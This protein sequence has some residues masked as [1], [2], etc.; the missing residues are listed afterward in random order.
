MRSGKNGIRL[1]YVDDERFLH[2]ALKLFMEKDGKFSVDT[3]PSEAKVLDSLSSGCYDAV[4]SDYQMPEMDGIAP[5][6]K[7]RQVGYQELTHTRGTY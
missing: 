6:R 1:L 5:L 2:E 7:L 4:V 3:V